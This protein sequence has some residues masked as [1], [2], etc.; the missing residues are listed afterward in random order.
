LSK[1]SG[2]ERAE[3]MTTRIT[4]LEGRV[5]GG[6]AL[7]RVEGKLALADAELLER[8]CA[9]LKAQTGASVTVD[10]TD[11]IFLDSESASVLARLRREHEVHLEGIHYFV[12]Q[13]IEIAERA[14]R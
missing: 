4:Q 11:I 1:A 8:V 9:D 13:V 10:L 5:A 6:R 3:E 12:Q 14:D 2:K 7:L